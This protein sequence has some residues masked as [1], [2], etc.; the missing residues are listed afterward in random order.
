MALFSTQAQAEDLYSQ[1]LLLAG[2]R[3]LASATSVDHWDLVARQ[4]VVLLDQFYVHLPLKR[5]S[6]GVDPVQDAR[7]LVDEVPFMPSDV[8]FF[9]RVFNIL[10]RLRDRHTA[11]RLPSP[12]RDMV[13]YLPFAVESYFDQAG[14]HLVVSKIMADT[15][16]A[17]FG[18]G[19]E[20]THWNGTPIRRHI[21]AL[22]WNT[23]GANP[24]ARVA[25]ALRSLTARPLGYMPQPDEDWV[26]ITYRS[27]KGAH[28]SVSVPW[29]IYFP[30][31]GSAASIAN[32]TASAN[33]VLFQ[34]VDRNTLIIN[35][36]WYD[37]FTRAT[38]ATERAG[39]SDL[40]DDIVQAKTVATPSGEWGY[41]RI[42]SF[43]VPD[44]AGF[45]NRV[46]GLLSQL[47]QNGLIV[48]VRA[49]P[50]GSIPAGEG[51]MRLF[52]GRVVESAPVSFRN[53]QAV[54]RLGGLSPFL[55]W[56]HSLDMQY[57]T[58]DVFS[59]GFAL[60][61]D[62]IGPRGVYS[63]RVVVIIDAL[64]YSTTDF[65][66]AG[67]QD[68]G[69]AE[70]LG[71][72]PVTGAGGANVWNH[73]VLGQFAA[74]GGGSDIQPLPSNIDID[75]SVRRSTRVG[76]SL[77]LPLEGLGVFADH[78][79]QLTRRDVLENNEDLIAFAGGIL[80]AGG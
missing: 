34:G 25:I 33:R 50:G 69:L 16:D 70:I 56:K 21:E 20:I 80:A 64:C 2:A 68:N 29:R 9:R 54:R 1:S 10:I 8:E 5:S 59:Q 36:T 51:L 19:V 38:P 60:T 3:D 48:D 11:I 72:D 62:E 24:F 30:E 27:N 79:Y 49:N 37:L 76:P 74:Q 52:T 15:G 42:F 6:L 71:V 44:P 46:A 31:T 7:L 67:M 43:E 65:F 35:N 47:P 78:Q 66:A 18:P 39:A 73:G 63:G 40:F 23:E 41:L 17:E 61:P 12:W 22:S 45:V 32:V 26:T 57:E 77:G 13:A 58:G 28:R 14:R 55:A 53:T 4:L 75:L